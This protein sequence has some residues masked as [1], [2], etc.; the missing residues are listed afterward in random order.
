MQDV[1]LHITDSHCG[2]SAAAHSTGMNNCNR[3]VMRVYWVQSSLSERG[4]IS[5][6]HWAW[7][8][9]PPVQAVNIKCVRHLATVLPNTNSIK[10]THSAIPHRIRIRFVCHF[11]PSTPSN[12]S[13][14]SLVV[15]LLPHRCFTHFFRNSGGTAASTDLLYSNSL[16][17]WMHFPHQHSVSYRRVAAFACVFIGLCKLDYP[18]IS[19]ARVFAF[20]CSF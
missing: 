14:Q 13:A 19:K 6:E 3:S 12:C 15:F 8:D 1:H 10:H 2:T 7:S 11:L 4:P 17:H 20:K 16:T 5:P 9:P 18:D